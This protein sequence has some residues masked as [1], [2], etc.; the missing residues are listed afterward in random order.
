MPFGMCPA[1]GATFHLNVADVGKCYE[2]YYPDVP[3]GEL[4]PAPCLYC[5]QELE[6][7]DRVIIRAPVSGRTNVAPGDRGVLKSIVSSKDGKLYLVELAS[8]AK[9]FIRTQVRKAREYEE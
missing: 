5:W 4:G 9:Y 3:V 2:E 6:I 8:G 7:G 1:C